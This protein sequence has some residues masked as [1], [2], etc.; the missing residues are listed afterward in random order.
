MLFES[1]KLSEFL[2]L[3]ELRQP[4]LTIETEVQTNSEHTSSPGK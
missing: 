3:C 2:K 4:L 1:E